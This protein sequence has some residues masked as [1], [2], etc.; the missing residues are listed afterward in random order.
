LINCNTY[1]F[2]GDIIDD[3]PFGIYKET[4]DRTYEIRKIEISNMADL[5]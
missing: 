3:E 4:N 2:L 1:K 5:V